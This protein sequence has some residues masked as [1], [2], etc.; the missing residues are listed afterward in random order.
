MK[1][2]V[3]GKLFQMAGTAEEWDRTLSQMVH[4]NAQK[5]A[6]VNNTFL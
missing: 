1:L 5:E 3:T 4:G 6:G 2:G